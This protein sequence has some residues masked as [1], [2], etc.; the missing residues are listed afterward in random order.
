MHKSTSG[1]QLVCAWAEL[2]VYTW[3]GHSWSWTPVCNVFLAF[4]SRIGQG[5]GIWTPVCVI[6]TR[7]KYELLYI[8]G[9]PWM[10][11]FQCNWKRAILSS[12]APENPLWVQGG[13]NPTAS[14][15]FLLP[16]NLIFAQVPQFQP[17]KTWNHRK[18]HKLIVKSRNVIFI[19][20]LMKIY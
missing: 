4:N 3:R 6:K 17:E 8:A 16:L 5:V 20:K 9:K 12:V 19:Q 14:A 2:E 7:A 10:S 18:T 1:A 15:V 13:Q 11:T